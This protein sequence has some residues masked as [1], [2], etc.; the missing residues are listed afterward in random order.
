MIIFYLKE[1]YEDNYKKKRK[2]GRIMGFKKDFI[3]GAAT[4]SYQVEGAAYKD[5]KGLNIWDVY[6]KQPGNVFED[7]NGDVACNQYELYKEDVQLMKE[8]NI[9][10]YRFSINWAR[11]IPEGTT[12][13]GGTVNEAGIDYYN[14]LIDELIANGIE[15]FITLY[16]W[17]LPYELQVK[18]GWLNDQIVDWFAEYA[19]LIA[20][21]FGDRVKNYFTVNE[22]EVFLGL[23][24]R[25]GTHAPGLKLGD[26]EFMRC[27]HNM[28]KAHGAAVR[29][30]RANCP[31]P[32]KIGMAPT[33][34]FCY[35]E[36]ESPED[37]AAAKEAMFAMD[38]NPTGAIWNFALVCD[39]VMLGH[40]PDSAIENFK[41]VMPEITE[42]D[43]KLISE[44]VDFFGFNLYNG[45][46]TKMGKD[47]KPERVKRYDGFPK[48]AI[49]WPVTPEA[50]RWATRFLYERY[51]KPIYITENGMSCHDW[52]A[53]DGKVHDPNRIDFYHRYLIELKKSAEEGTDIEGYFAW[54]LM[55]NFE[56]TNGYHDRFGIIYVDYP[57]QK[58]IV[59][60]SG[61]W[62]RDMIAENG[63]NL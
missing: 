14:R 31:Q 30:L 28:L 55:D 23:G 3:W 48:T 39:P 57:T 43:M 50:I 40:Y 8:L 13:F 34:A 49:Q 46:M 52:V 4:A 60:D 56:W 41:D 61:Y 15:P 5:G 53:L 19:T 25:E 1:A 44:P 45:V 24:Y 12:A 58:R 9:K 62:Y 26:R 17:D 11:I 29:A 7:Q 54:S 37:I 42:E 2:V 35:P 33:G 47:G 38:K 21:R 22:P 18:G 20:K 27:V 36:T 16:H 59:K 6:C 51:G 63:E 10:A 32:V